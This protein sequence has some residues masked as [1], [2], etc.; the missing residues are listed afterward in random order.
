M[1]L[2]LTGQM[3]QIGILGEAGFKSMKCFQLVTG[4]PA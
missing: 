4:L 3:M 2:V 1:L